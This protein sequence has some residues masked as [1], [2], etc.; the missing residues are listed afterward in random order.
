MQ[1]I[2]RLLKEAK[3]QSKGG[4]KVG[5]AMITS[6]DEGKSWELAIDLT[7]GKG[8]GNYKRITLQAESIERAEELLE[9]QKKEYGAIDE[10]IPVIIDDYGLM[11]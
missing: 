7:D 1:K 6:K 2:N 11:N 4:L 3:E 5:L 9:E 10:D 8:K